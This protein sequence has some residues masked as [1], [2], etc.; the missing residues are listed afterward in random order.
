MKMN[1]KNVF[2]FKLSKAIE[3]LK[4]I[5][6]LLFQRKNDILFNLKYERFDVL[7]LD[8]FIKFN[9]SVYILLLFHRLLN[10]NSFICSTNTF[11]LQCTVTFPLKFKKTTNWLDSRVKINVYFVV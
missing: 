9:E 4:C 6:S 8:K 7:Q 10:S 11:L 3:I 1:V 5:Y 2:S